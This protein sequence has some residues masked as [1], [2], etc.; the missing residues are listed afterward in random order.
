MAK[1]SKIDRTPEVLDLALYA[2]DGVTIRLALTDNQGNPVD[3]AGELKA[4][5][6]QT[7]AAP[8]IEAEFTATPDGETGAILISLTGEETASLVTAGEDFR[9][10]WDIQWIPLQ[11][12][13]VTLTKGEV[14]C[15]ADVTR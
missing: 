7:K 12:Q 14:T 13:P 11:G 1:A 10:V 8:D 9:G 15:A 2:G 6:R 5:I 3:I 4:Q